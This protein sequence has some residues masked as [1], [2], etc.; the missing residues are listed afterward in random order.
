M[1]TRQKMSGTVS[2]KPDEF[3]LFTSAWCRRHC[4]LSDSSAENYSN[5]NPFQDELLSM[6]VYSPFENIIGVP[7]TVF[8]F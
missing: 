8:R 1:Y 3:V 6:G 2:L 4:L 7:L 5:L